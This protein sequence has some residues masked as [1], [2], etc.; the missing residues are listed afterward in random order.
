ML[1]AVAAALTALAA[2]AAG[3]ALV[4]YPVGPAL[5]ALVAGT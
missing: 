5:R 2:V 4:G 1:R 3:L